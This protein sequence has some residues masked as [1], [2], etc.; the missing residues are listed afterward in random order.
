MVR[1]PE[2]LNIFKNID[3]GPEPIVDSDKSTLEQISEVQFLL[4][5]LSDIERELKA[6][7][8]ALARQSQSL[9][10][11]QAGY[12]K[13]GDPLYLP[14]IEDFKT[15]IAETAAYIAD[16]ESDQATFKQNLSALEAAENQA[17]E[18][19]VR[20]RIFKGKKGSALGPQ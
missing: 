18:D 10:A 5:E 17:A 12:E 3:S 6:K 4:T 8:S 1:N 15:Q 14:N 19:D 2:Y 9:A 16:L 13:T 7:K 11:D 20:N